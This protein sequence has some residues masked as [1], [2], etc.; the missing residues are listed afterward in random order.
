MSSEARVST[1]TRKR[2][3][4]YERQFRRDRLLMGLC[5]QC[6]TPVP[7]MGRARCDYHA[8]VAADRERQ[9]RRKLRHLM[10]SE[11]G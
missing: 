1:K 4:E 6:N 11:R 8:Q 2:Y 9:R 7:E 3:R 5:L 10:P